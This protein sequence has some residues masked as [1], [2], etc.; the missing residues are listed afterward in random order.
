MEGFWEGG[1][2]GCEVSG[3]GQDGS[4]RGGVREEGADR[5]DDSK[6]QVAAAAKWMVHIDAQKQCHHGGS[7]PYGNNINC[8]CVDWTGAASDLAASLQVGKKRHC[9]DYG[10]S[11]DGGRNVFSWLSASRN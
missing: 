11:G 9:G 7:T 4:P 10:V 2:K 1:S 8:V 3:A 5:V 6:Q